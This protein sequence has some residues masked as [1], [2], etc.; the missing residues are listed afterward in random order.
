MQYK[1][2]F[3]AVNAEVAKRDIF[4]TCNS[5][6]SQ[7]RPRLI[8]PIS[9]LRATTMA[10]PP[11]DHTRIPSPDFGSNRPTK[12]RSSLH[13]QSVLHAGSRRQVERGQLV[14]ISAHPEESRISAGREAYGRFEIGSREWP[15]SSTADGGE[16]D[17]SPAR[18]R[19]GQSSLLPLGRYLM[20]EGAVI[21]VLSHD[22]GETG[23][24]E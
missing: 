18:L 16:F 11:T 14:E 9:R 21:E 20:W 3:P 12:S 22:L 2:C 17:R 15:R 6:K 19:Q 1:G 24:S 4:A 13:P 7:G 10:R 23:F 5:L 8:V